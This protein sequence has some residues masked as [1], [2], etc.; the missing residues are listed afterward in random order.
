[1]SAAPL[2]ILHADDL[3]LAVDKPSGLSVHRGLDASN[4][5]LIARLDALGHGGAR[6]VHRLDRGTS[7]VLLAARK[8]SAAAALGRAMAAGH[9]TKTYLALVRGLAPEHVV[10]DHP[11]PADEDGERVAAVTT[12]TR[13]ARVVVD[14]SALRE[15]RYSLVR[16]E[17]ATGRFHQIRRHLKHLGHPVVGDTTY[18]RAEHNR[19]CAER[20]GLRRLAL[21]AAAIALP[22]PDGS[23]EL[24][25]ESPLPIDLERP[26]RAMGLW[27][28]ADAGASGR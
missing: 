3:V 2:V 27:P 26:L 19:L 4:D 25:V 21:H 13:I 18:G 11:V 28:C 15:A 6:P 12:I 20:F 22:H 8:A 17:P 5:T 24:R 14:G 9:A 7:G 16:A 10:V 1:M 23:G